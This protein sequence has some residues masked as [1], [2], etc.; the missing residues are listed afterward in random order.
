MEVMHYCYNTSHL[1]S[2]PRSG[3]IT[4]LFEHSD[5]LEKKNWLPITLL[6]VDYK[7]AAKALANHLL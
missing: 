2:S 4:L 1:S 7:I 6:C 3:L 5:R